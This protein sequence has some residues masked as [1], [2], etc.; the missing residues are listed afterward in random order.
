MA[1]IVG[2]VRRNISR[3]GPCRNDKGPTRVHV[4]VDHYSDA[5]ATV[6]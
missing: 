6:F 2:S 5:P 4:L 1:V 3:D